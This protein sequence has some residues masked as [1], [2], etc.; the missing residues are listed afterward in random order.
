MLSWV[1]V[2]LCK[3]NTQASVGMPTRSQLA[4]ASERQL[5]YFISR[6]GYEKVAKEAGLNFGAVDQSVSLY[7]HCSCSNVCSNI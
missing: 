6:H 4:S 1:S 7:L 5:A 2:R 3:T